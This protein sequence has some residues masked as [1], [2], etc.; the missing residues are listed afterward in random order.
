M[1]CIAFDGTKVV[2]HQESWRHI[3]FRHPELKNWSALILF[4]VAHPDEVY[5]DSQRAHF[6]L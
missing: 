2:L 5:V 6:M 4:A 3:T 1:S